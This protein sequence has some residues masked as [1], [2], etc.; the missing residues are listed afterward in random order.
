LRRDNQKPSPY[1]IRAVG[2]DNIVGIAALDQLHEQEVPPQVD[3]R[4]PECDR[5]VAGYVRVI[6]GERERTIWRVAA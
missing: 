2:R 1:V 4:D 3:T 5:D 6:T